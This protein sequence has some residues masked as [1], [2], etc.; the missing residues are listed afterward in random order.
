MLEKSPARAVK[1]F[2]PSA[3]EEDESVSRKTIL[4]N[5]EV[6]NILRITL[7]DDP[8][9]IGYVMLVFFAGL[10]PEREATG[11]A[12]GNIDFDENLLYVSPK[13]A[14]DRRERY[15]EM[16]PALSI[17]LKAAAALDACLPVTNL[18][19]RWESI[20][21][22]AGLFGAT[23]PHDAGRHTFASNHLVEY[24]G[25]ATK[26]ALGHGTYDMLFRNYRTLVKPT[27]AAGY[28]SIPGKCLD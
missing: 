21:K 18:K 22:K 28:W 3:A 6:E 4:S 7:K 19:R 26:A 17:G 2:K 5:A 20:R 23:W 11:V 15:I 27:Q 10:R 16:P 9:L 13:A 25:D 8:A 24:G 12:W 14:K 1:K